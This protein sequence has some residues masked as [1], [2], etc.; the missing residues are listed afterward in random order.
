MTE[1][2]KPTGKVIQRVNLNR[3]MILWDLDRDRPIL[4][5]LPGGV[6]GASDQSTQLIQPMKPIM[7]IFSSIDKL[8]ECLT[9]FDPCCHWAVKCIEDPEKFLR[10]IDNRIILGLDPY[11]HKGNTR[12]LQVHR[13]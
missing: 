13:A 5:G 4:M 3:G 2:I 8:K 6:H 11:I 9:W 1:N 7:P 12:W 10:S